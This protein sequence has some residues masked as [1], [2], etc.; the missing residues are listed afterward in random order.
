MKF[1]RQVISCIIYDIIGYTQNL[2]LTVICK[3][4]D[5][6]FIK[7]TSLFIKWIGLVWETNNIK[8]IKEIIWKTCEMMYVTL[9]YWKK[10]F[11]Q[12]KGIFELLYELLVVMLLL[13]C[14]NLIFFLPF[15][16]LSSFKL[17]NTD[18]NLCSLGWL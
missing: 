5:S 10:G 3:I 11:W 8:T 2:S 17:Y 12:N 6:V 9:H 13:I 16:H 14:V 7:N 15:P 4:Y 18:A 1:N